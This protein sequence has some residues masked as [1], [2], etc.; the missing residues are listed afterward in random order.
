MDNITLDLM[1]FLEPCF[2]LEC[3]K[4]MTIIR[5][6]KSKDIESNLTVFASTITHQIECP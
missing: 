4:I 1:N 2:L 3:N 6:T 5:G